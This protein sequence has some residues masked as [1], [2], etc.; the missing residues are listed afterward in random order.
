MNTKP[1]YESVKMERVRLKIRLENSRNINWDLL[2]YTIL[3][4]N[5]I[6]TR[7]KSS[8]VPSRRHEGKLRKTRRK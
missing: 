6:K 8:Q 1:R 2:L 3:R 4:I 7:R 5:K